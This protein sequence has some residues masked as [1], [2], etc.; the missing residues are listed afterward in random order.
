MGICD[1]GKSPLSSAL[2]TFL[3]LGF[4]AIYIWIDL[5]VKKNIKTARERY[6]GHAM[7]CPNNSKI[8]FWSPEIGIHAQP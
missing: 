7:A 8:T 4:L 5:D 2:L 6:P 3:V 1:I